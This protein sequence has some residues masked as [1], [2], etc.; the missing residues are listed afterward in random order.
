MMKALI[1]SALNQVQT[2]ADLKRTTR[3]ILENRNT[4]TQKE[5][6]WQM[7]KY[8]LAACTFI[9]LCGLSVG[10]YFYY[11]TPVNYLSLDIN[12]SVELG[13]NA[14]DKVVSATGYNVDGT[15]ILKGQDVTN[16]SVKDA[17]KDLVLSAAKNGFIN[18]DGSTIISLTAETNNP[19]TAS[20]LEESSEQGAQEATNTAH[21]TAVVFKTNVA[22]ARRD[23]ARKLGITPGKLN[24]IQKLQALDAT[25]T[26]DEYKDA[27]VTDIMKKIIEL[28]KSAKGNDSASPDS[29]LNN[30]ESAVSQAEKDQ[31]QVQTQKA[32]GNSSSSGS[33]KG[34]T[35]QSIPKDGNSS[36]S[37]VSSDRNSGIGSNESSSEANSE[38]SLTSISNHGSTS[39]PAKVQSGRGGSIGQGKER[40]SDKGK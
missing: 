28:K 34:K 12:P 40:S 22:L 37:S 25:T 2:E 10:G 13:I 35:K 14:F 21:V 39:V 26:I 8:A 11:H 31:E 4:S 33:A 36:A 16:S 20:N 27:K 15:T 38:Q 19:E 5:V 29:G 6:G 18:S 24:L 1:K 3:E 17:V 32:G 7:K 23:E 30:I 9:L